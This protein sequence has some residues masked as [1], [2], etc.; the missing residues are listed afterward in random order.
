MLSYRATTREEMLARL[1]TQYLSRGYVLYV[2]GW[3]PLHKDP[4]RVD[5]K[6]AGL[7]G[8]EQSKSGRHRRLRR[9]LANLVYVRC[10][11][12]FVLVSTVGQHVFL[13]RESSMLRDARKE[14][15]FLGC[16]AVRVTPNGVQ[17]TLRRRVFD[18]IKRRFRNRALRRTADEL[19]ESMRQLPFRRYAGIVQQLRVVIAQVN[20]IRRTAGL[21]RIPLGAAGLPRMR[22]QAPVQSGVTIRRA[23][24][25]PPASRV[26]AA[27][28]EQSAE[29]LILER[30][31]QTTEGAW[32]PSVAPISDKGSAQPERVPPSK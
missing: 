32:E 20:R 6:L 31:L 7:Y 13:D 14:P 26:R 12:E 1:V 15:L 27:R 24:R 17:V 2:R 18:W 9:G 21:D 11:H 10:R 23:D 4:E 19:V 25:P 30:D 16:Y 3:I 5:Q 22:R 29:A 28:P 8:P